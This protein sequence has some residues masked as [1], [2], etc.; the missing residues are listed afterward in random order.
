MEVDISY[1]SV[2]FECPKCNYVIEVLLRQVMAEET[3]LCPGC[4]VE[5]QLQDE[6]GSVRRSGPDIDSALSDLKR[7]LRRLGGG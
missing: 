7:Q 4:Y 1:Q 3:V 2:Q 5:I 6:G